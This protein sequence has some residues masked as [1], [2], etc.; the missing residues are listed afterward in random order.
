MRKENM[1][2]DEIDKIEEE[3]FFTLKNKI[4]NIPANDVEKIIREEVKKRRY[5]TEDWQINYAVNRIKD[6]LKGDPKKQKKQKGGFRFILLA[7]I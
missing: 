6:R 2:K 1:H 4:T 5:L 3:I 7:K